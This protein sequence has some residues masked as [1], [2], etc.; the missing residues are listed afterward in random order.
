MKFNILVAT[1]ACL[2]AITAAVDV[3]FYSD[4]T[5]GSKDV[6]YSTNP[7]NFVIG[8]CKEYAEYPYSKVYAKYSSCGAQVKFTI[9][10]ESA[11][12]GDGKPF[13][14]DVGVCLA[15]L[16]KSAASSTKVTCS[17]KDAASSVT[18][19]FLNFLAVAAAALVLFF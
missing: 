5:C 7:V 4:K 13:T 9:H 11:C 2:F 12:L 15:D 1:A 18:T 16:E 6:S 10:A 14:Q 19:A 8:E 3:T 17:V